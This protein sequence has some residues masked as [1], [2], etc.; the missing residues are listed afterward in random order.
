MTPKEIPCKNNPEPFVANEQ[1]Q[2]KQTW[3]E[4]EG[5]EAWVPR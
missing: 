4:L 3:F 1:V 5:M 2:R